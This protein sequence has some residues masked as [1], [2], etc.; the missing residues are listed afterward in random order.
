M[1]LNRKDFLTALQT[2]EPALETRDLVPLLRLL[3]FDGRTVR[4]T[5]G[6]LG[7]E[8]PCI[9][10]FKGGLPGKPLIGFIDSLGRDKINIEEE[11]DK[12][13]T[14]V[15]DKSRIRL[16]LETITKS[17]WPF[18]LGNAEPEAVLSL[19]AEWRQALEFSMLSVSTTAEQEQRRGVTFSGTEQKLNL[20]STDGASIAWAQM[21]VAEWGLD[22]FTIPGEFVKETLKQMSDY[23]V[24][25]I[26]PNHIE[27]TNQAGVHI[28][29]KMLSISDPIN[30]ARTVKRYIK[31]I[32]LVQIPDGLT[33]ALQRA[34]LLKDKDGISAKFNFV[35]KDILVIEAS[36]PYGDLKEELIFEGNHA[37][38]SARFTPGILLRG[39]EGRKN[40]VV[41]DRCAILNGPDNLHYMVAVYNTKG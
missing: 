36:S 18:T 17:V 15:S 39:L 31:D 19:D 40:F 7:I 28:H 16:P 41:S 26:R 3:W 6:N 32:N 12:S 29:S 24:L 35:D 27:A 8:A 25:S 33:E 1:E 11:D 30:Y 9:T 4:A 20:Y 10:E 5:D 38:L 22:D 34:E 23:G 37:E 13:I 14:F 2:V 21:A